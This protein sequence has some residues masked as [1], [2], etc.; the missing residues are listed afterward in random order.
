MRAACFRY[1]PTAGVCRLPSR[2]W[3]TRSR[4]M[5]GFEVN[6]RSEVLPEITL[7]ETPASHL[8]RIAQEAITNAARHGRASKVDIVLIA[9]RNR[10]VLEIADDGVGLG[11]S[12]EPETG[13][14]LRIMRYRADMIGAK[15]EIDA[16]K[17]RGTVVRVT[18]EQPSGR[19]RRTTATATY[20]RKGYLWA[21]AIHG[22]ARR[23]LNPGPGRQA[24]RPGVCSSSTIIRSC[25]RDLRR[26][27]GER[28]RSDGLRRGG[29]ARR[30]ARTAIKEL[31]PDVV[32]ADISLKQGDGIELVR[33]RA[34]P[35][36]AAADPGAVHAR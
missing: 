7:S 2:R 3:P 8:Y 24:Q 22:C 16:N 17:P 15:F 30:D 36:P 20:V 1:V 34:R 32:I 11:G 13:M 14:G 28:G 19:V 27:H 12:Q 5:Y 6:F 35:L 10:I 26:R 29:D 18:S 21:L 31:N 23:R 33:D 9:N 25:A 4:E